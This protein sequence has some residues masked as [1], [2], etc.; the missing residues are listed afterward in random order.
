MRSKSHVIFEIEATE[1]TNFQTLPETSKELKVRL[2]KWL[3]A[4]R[5]FKTRA[6]ARSAIEQGRVWYNGE[7]TIPSKEIAVNA[8]VVISQGASRKMIT[9]QVRKLSTRR[10]S[11][12]ESNELFALLEQ[13]EAQELHTNS[14]TDNRPRKMTRFLRRSLGNED[15]RDITPK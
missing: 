7:K 12:E 14:V 2:D 15:T 3:W 4:A 13:N 10:R 1:A 8:T 6:L 9:L 11:T 5:F